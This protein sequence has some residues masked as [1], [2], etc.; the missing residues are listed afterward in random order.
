MPSSVKGSM[1]W[2]KAGIGTNVRFGRASV[3]GE[4]G[5]ITN[6]P[7]V[8]RVRPWTGIDQVKVV[9]LNREHKIRGGSVVGPGMVALWTTDP[10]S[11]IGQSR[12]WTC[13][14]QTCGKTCGDW[15]KSHIVNYDHPY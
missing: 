5:S 9:T 8:M 6:L 4:D 15:D 12:T 14:N 1:N 10:F 7:T 13:K 3:T 11:V 2:Y